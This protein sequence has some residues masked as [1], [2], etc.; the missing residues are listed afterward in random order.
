MVFARNWHVLSRDLWEGDELRSQTLNG[1]SYVEGNPVNWVDPTGYQAECDETGYCWE[2]DRY[3]CGPNTPGGYDHRGKPCVVDP[4]NVQTGNA[5]TPSPSPFQ[6][7]LT[8]PTSP[9]DIT[10]RSHRDERDLTP[11]LFAELKTAIYNRD[12]LFISTLVGVKSLPSESVHPSVGYGSY[13]AAMIMWRQLVRDRAR[14]D[15]KHQILRE[16]NR[17][18]LFRTENGNLLWSEY[19]LPGNIF[20]GYIGTRIGF[21]GWLT[22]AGAGFAEAVDPAHEKIRNIC[23]IAYLPPSR[24]PTLGDDPADYRSV[25]FGIELW[26]KYGASLSLPQFRR[27]LEQNY[28][29]F[30]PPLALPGSGGIPDYPWKNP[31]GGWPYDVG[32]FNGSREHEHWPPKLENGFGFYE[33]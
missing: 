28:H 20:F 14:Y 4:N 6:P 30:A 10:W 27:E 1:W 8:S 23:G 18:I 13:G 33:P 3:L 17:T 7:P 2:I 15:F 5:P 12:I 19:S 11:W 22:H 29:K 24:I 16:L 26:K 32:D 25:E 21:P 9:T 31:R